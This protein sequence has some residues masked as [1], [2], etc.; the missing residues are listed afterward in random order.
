MKD[1][2]PDILTKKTWITEEEGK[3][4]FTKIDETWNW[5]ENKILE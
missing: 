3:D 5:V 1:N 4:V 2:L